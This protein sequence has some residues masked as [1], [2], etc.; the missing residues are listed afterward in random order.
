MALKP[1]ELGTVSKEAT[2]KIIETPHVVALKAPPITTRL[3][4]FIWLVFSNESCQ[5]HLVKSEMTEF[6]GIMYLQ[7]TESE[8]IKRR[9]HPLVDNREP[10]G[11]QNKWYKCPTG[12]SSLL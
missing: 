5:N 12:L 1:T 4:V 2:C 6:Q 11:T 9:H 8:S 3:L 10:A 7:A